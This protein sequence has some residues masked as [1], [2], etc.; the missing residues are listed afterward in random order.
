MT[1]AWAFS[2]SA[3]RSALPSFGGERAI[4]RAPRQLEVALPLVAG[5]L[6]ADDPLDARPP[7]RHGDVPEDDRA[8]LAAR[9][10]DLLAA[11]GQ[12]R[13]VLA[14]VHEG[15]AQGAPGRGVPESQG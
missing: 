8:V 13:D 6:T 1:S 14:V 4:P 2:I 3:K 9:G 7:S 11:E 5:Q 15:L 10:K 12:P